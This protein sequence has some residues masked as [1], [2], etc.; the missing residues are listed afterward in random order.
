MCS[1]EN[2]IDCLAFSYIIYLTSIISF[3]HSIPFSS[4]HNT[5]KWKELFSWKGTTFVYVLSSD[6]LH[7]YPLPDQFMKLMT[8]LEH[9]YSSFGHSLAIAQPIL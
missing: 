4:F 9:S 8:K 3:N 1:Q 5:T 6:C 7:E 2:Y